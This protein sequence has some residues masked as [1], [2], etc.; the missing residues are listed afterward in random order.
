ML[1]SSSTDFSPITLHYLTTSVV[2]SKG[3]FIYTSTF[4]FLSVIEL[5]LVNQS[6][7]TKSK[8][9]TSAE[10]KGGIRR[11]LFFAIVFQV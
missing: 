10:K 4:L 5:T 8:I 9:P 7:I 3:T 11:L 1:G 2:H 6:A